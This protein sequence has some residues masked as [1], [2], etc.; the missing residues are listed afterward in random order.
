M[1]Y[2]QQ[3]KD[4][5]Y[6]YKDHLDFIILTQ[7]KSV[8][9]ELIME[10]M[11]L[12]WNLNEKGERLPLPVGYCDKLRLGHTAKDRD[13]WN[14]IESVCNPYWTWDDMAPKLD[15]WMIDSRWPDVFGRWFF[16]NW[17]ENPAIM[18][19]SAEKVFDSLRKYLAATRI[20]RTFRRCISS[21]SH[22]MCKRR[23]L[24]EYDGFVCGFTV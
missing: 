23:L 17:S 19:T 11:D 5:L 16:Q 14:Y 22:K 15:K 9:M 24:R 21:P 2:L 12:P 13:N 20:Q 4:F 8:S 18:N 7:N 1:E 10:T 6:K 3:R